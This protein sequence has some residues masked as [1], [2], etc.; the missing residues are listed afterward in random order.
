S[1]GAAALQDFL[2]VGDV[3]MLRGPQST[4]FGKNTTAGAVLVSSVAPSPDR[5]GATVE[6]SYG[7]YA[8]YLVRAALN[9]PLSDKAALRVS[10]LA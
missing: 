2:D 6:A 5:A 7:S 1:R 4:L 9:L 8:S 3:Q 10:G